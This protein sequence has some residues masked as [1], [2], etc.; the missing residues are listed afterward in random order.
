MKATELRIGNWIELKDYPTTPHWE[1][2]S[3]G[4]LLQIG[5]QLWSIEEFKPIPLTE[6]WLVRFGLHKIGDIWEFW[7]NSEWHLYED[8]GWYLWN[9]N[10]RV[11]CVEIKNVH[12]LQNLYFA[13]T[14]EEL[15]INEK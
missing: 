3:I 9:G 2:E 8:G 11:D 10:V 4:N 15:K 12:Q 7:K 1:V 14:G 13:L 5:G 6:E